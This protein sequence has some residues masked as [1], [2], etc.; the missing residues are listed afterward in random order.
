ML[1]CYVM[2]GILWFLAG[3]KPWLKSKQSKRFS[4][5]W[6]LKLI[7]LSLKLNQ[8][9]WNFH[10]IHFLLFFLS[11]FQWLLLATYGKHKFTNNSDKSLQ[12]QAF[13]GEACYALNNNNGIHTALIHRCS[14]RFT[15]S[16]WHFRS[17]ISSVRTWTNVLFAKKTWARVNTTCLFGKSTSYRKCLPSLF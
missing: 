4:S 5:S 16:A 9:T 6:A 2:P 11:L 15:F 17:Q 10:L 13:S 12:L 3:S 8:N 7:S 14:K 1:Q